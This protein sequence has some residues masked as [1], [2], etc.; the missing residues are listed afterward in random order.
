MGTIAT[1]DLKPRSITLT[2]SS[3]DKV[4]QGNY[5]LSLTNVS[6]K[7]FNARVEI[8]PN[9]NTQAEWILVDRT[10]LIFEFAKDRVIDI[11]ISI[12]VPGAV[13]EGTFG[14]TATVVDA[15]LPDER[16]AKLTGSFDVPKAALQPPH[17]PKK[18]WLIPVIILAVLLLGG[19]VF[20]IHKLTSGG[21]PKAI[22]ALVQPDAA[23]QPTVV[24]TP[25]PASTEYD[26]Q[27][28]VRIV[29]AHSR[30]CLT[31]AGGIRDLNAELVQYP[32]DDD[33]SRFWSISAIKGTRLVAIKN[34]NSGLCLTIAGGGGGANTTAV[35]YNCD[36]DP[37]RR[38]KMSPAPVSGFRLVNAHSGLCLTVAGGGSERNTPAV[39]YPCDGDPSRDWEIRAAE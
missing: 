28:R 11:P 16:Y 21:P 26:N 4:F 6:G 32:C 38:W 19:G 5:K 17:P 34:L 14:F 33:P 37:S 22:T 25:H 18:M 30:L 36:D 8:R 20:A 3:D 23:I 10:S 35:Q 7:Q 27:P 24:G 2:R 31:V 13:P 9:G 12:K 15:E 29:N 1:I 39:Q